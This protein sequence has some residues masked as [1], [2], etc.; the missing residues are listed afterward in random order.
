MLFDDGDDSIEDMFDDAESSDLALLALDTIE[1]PPP[2]ATTNLIGHQ[3]IEQQL[4]AM[5]D[6]HRF[7][8][9]IIFSG[10]EGIGKSVMAFRLARYLFAKG[11]A[12]QDDTFN[13]FGNMFGDAPAKDTS[14]FIPAQDA[15]FSQVSSGGHPDMRVIGRTYDDKADKYKNSVAI[16]SIR[17]IAPFMRQTA[18]NAGGWRIAIVDDA[19]LMT[20]EAQNSLLKILEEPPE[21][22][23]LILIAHRAGALLPTIYSRCVH[24]P[25]LPLSDAD[26][27]TAIKG[28]C[29]NDKMPLIVAM[30][31][32]SLGAAYE[33]TDP[34][35]D[36]VIIGAIDLLKSGGK[37]EWQKIQ[38][39]AETFGTKGDDISQR[40]FKEA[41]LWVA[42]SLVRGK[43]IGEG[44]EIYQALPLVRRIKL[45]D[46]LR[47]HFD[48][49]SIGALDKRF[50][51]MGAY[52]AFEG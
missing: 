12:Q 32:G 25:F 26:I 13:M 31:E 29:S 9:G 5:L 21:K 36:D 2:R 49:C 19:D 51:I 10:L 38:S 47:A 34:H 6:N 18:S 39:F 40:L 17:K 35:H 7:P 50:L 48:R 28:R 16:D 41:I 15:V 37:L 27:Q 45:Y 1:I 44:F 11:G 4:L 22:S 43:S 3:A 52:M 14:L 8:H 24:I 42:S 30:A 46:D 20:H 33:Y 23:V